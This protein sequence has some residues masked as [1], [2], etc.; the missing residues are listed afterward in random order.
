MKNILEPLTLQTNIKNVQQHSIHLKILETAQA[1][2][3]KALKTNLDR[4][5]IRNIALKA[6]KNTTVSD[7]LET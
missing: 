3:F 6:F 4:N 2:T 7:T 5:S 1:L